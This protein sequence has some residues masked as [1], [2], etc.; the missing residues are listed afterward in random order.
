M[1]LKTTYVDFMREIYIG[2]RCFII[3]LDDYGYEEKNEILATTASAFN[4][5]II[6]NDM[7]LNQCEDISELYKQV[8]KVNPYTKFIIYCNG[9]RRLTNV[10]NII[11]LEFFVYLDA[12]KINEQTI[13]WLS[14]SGAKFIFDNKD[15]DSIE[16]VNT[17]SM[18]LLIKKHQIFINLNKYTEEEYHQIK[19]Y[20]YNLY[21]EY[22]GEWI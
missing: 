21:I 4:L 11:N 13:K 5:V 14:K 7:N 15:D 6:K 1:K 3:E 17:L 10:G 8:Q 2:Q 16:Y 12:E 19:S 22:E 18:A 20:G 9:T